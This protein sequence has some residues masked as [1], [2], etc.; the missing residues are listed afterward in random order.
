MTAARPK[1]DLGKEL[2]KPGAQFFLLLLLS[3]FLTAL[4]L[5]RTLER[6]AGL[7]T[8]QDEVAQVQRQVE[9]LRAQV[10]ELASL[11]V[12]LAELEAQVREATWP[13]NPQA[14]GLAWLEGILRREGWRVEG[15]EV[16]GAPPFPGGVEAAG[17][18]LKGQVPDYRAL[19]K[20]LEEVLEA[21]VALALIGI[22]AGEGLEVRLSLKVPLVDGKLLGGTP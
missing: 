6:T 4:L 17:V 5:P 3:L 2:R 9:E 14:E 11:R 8:L 21:R 10:G 7:S 22:D 13:P 18:E 20:G 1:R 19:R 16:K 15:L 12:R